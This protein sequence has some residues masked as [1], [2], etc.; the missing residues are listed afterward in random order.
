MNIIFSNY[1]DDL[2][3]CGSGAGY[4]TVAVAKRLAKKGH[5]MHVVCSA[6]PGSK[7]E[8]REGVTYHYIGS[9]KAGPRLS[10]IIYQLLLPLYALKSRRK[11]D[12][13]VEVFVPPWS[14]AFLPLFT[15]KTV[16]GLPHFLGARDLAKKFKIP[17]HWI[18]WLGLKTYRFLLPLTEHTKQRLEKLNPRA[19]IQ[20][21]PNGTEEHFVDIVRQP[22]QY[23]LY[24]GRVDIFNKGLDLL[25]ES[26]SVFF[27]NNTSM[28]LVVAGGG[29]QADEDAFKILLEEKGIMSR[30]RFVGYVRG[31]EKEKLYAEATA[32]LIPSRWEQMSIV[33]L[34]ALAIG[35]PIVAFNIDDFKWLSSD[36]AIK[37]PAFDTGAY[38]RAIEGL[39]ADPSLQ[40]KKSGA[41]KNFARRYTWD[42]IAVQYETFIR[43]AVG[44]TL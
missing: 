4:A 37:V 25:A 20:I 41:A 31:T 1:N 38:A 18:E 23:F 40:E 2:H 36:C 34:E 9:A 43:E 42:T 32:V 17:F 7:N 3:P 44:G 11:F 35:Q 39:V 19:K 10:L 30:V 24:L 15:R 22:K 21:I 14:T 8:I 13:W 16:I 12:A 28:E 27:K 29:N 6:Y 5:T 26:M 33:A